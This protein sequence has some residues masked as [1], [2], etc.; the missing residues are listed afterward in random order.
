MLVH[1]MFVAR[2]GLK[3]IRSGKTVNFKQ[4][5]KL[6][7]IPLIWKKY[8]FSNILDVLT[9]NIIHNIMKVRIHDNIHQYD[10]DIK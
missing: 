1:N 7:F 9:C 6:I 3:H 4:N 2:Y 8:F 10:I 5:M